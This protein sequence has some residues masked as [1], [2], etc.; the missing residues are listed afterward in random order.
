[1][2]TTDKPIGYWLKHVHNLIETQFDGALADFEVNRRQWQVMNLLSCGPQSRAQADEV[3]APFWKD[4]AAAV[5]EPAHLTTLLDG[6]SG[7][8]TRGRVRYAPETDLL[9]LT[10]EGQAEHA[11]VAARVRD[12][13]GTVLR[14]LTLEQY[15]ETVHILSVMAANLESALADHGTA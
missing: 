10:A 14:G 1:M 3:L 4:A 5:G 13:R 15:T 9:A 8:I 2:D 12:I 11:A 6:P 7:L